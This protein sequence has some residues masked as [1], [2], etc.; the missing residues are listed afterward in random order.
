MLNG[1][2]YNYNGKSYEH[3]WYYINYIMVIL[4]L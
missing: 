1:K 2:L 4:I 3:E